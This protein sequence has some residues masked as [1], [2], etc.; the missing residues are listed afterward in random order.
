M[1]L[2]N[3]Q[4]QWKNEGKDLHL[5]ISKEANREKQDEIILQDVSQSITKVTLGE[6][7]MNIEQL[8]QSISAVT[9]QDPEAQGTDHFV[10][11]FA[12]ENPMLSMV[13]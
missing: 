7:N 12:S 1:T 11:D 5:L 8:I 10:T 4:Y 9:H 13:L 6:N 2:E 3:I